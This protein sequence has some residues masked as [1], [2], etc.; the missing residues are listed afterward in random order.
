M[1]K[2]R[3][4]WIDIAKGIGILL[5]VYG[6]ALGGIMNTSGIGVHNSLTIPYNVIY[7]FHM[8]LFFFLA[9]MFVHNWAS[10][11]VKVALS[12]KFWS[13]VIPYFIWTVITGSVMALVRKY[14][15]AGLGVKDILLS[16]IAPFS[17]YWFLYVLF[18]VFIIYYVMV[19]L[20]ND[21]ALIAIAL[22]LFLL[23]PVL[24]KYWIFDALSLNFLWFVLGAEFQQ[25][26]NLNRALKYNVKKLWLSLI[27]FLVVN[28]SYL[29]VL[30]LNV[31]WIGS[32]YKIL[33][34]PAGL[35]VVIYISQLFERYITIKNVLSWLGG[36]SMAIYV[37]HLIPV[38]GCRIVALKLIG[39]QNLISLS[40]IITFVALIACVSVYALIMNTVVGNVIFG[41]KLIKN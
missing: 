28:I 12:Q 27:V 11:P 30:K 9:G 36:A 31:Y 34:V 32:Y 40:I 7:G 4:V 29:M 25:Q 26:T 15:N 18:I 24:Y 38:A 2:E 5:V 8:P 3:I 17:E 21:K 22:L 6:H 1:N 16:P 37:M 23:R 19:R 39:Y 35:L 13:L 14:T 41:K 20:V 33:T 10:R